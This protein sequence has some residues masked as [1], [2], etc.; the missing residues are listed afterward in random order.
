MPPDAFSIL[1]NESQLTTGYTLEF[2]ELADIL[3]W[4]DSIRLVTYPRGL[5]QHIRE[6]L[7]TNGPYDNDDDEPAFFRMTREAER[8]DSELFSV[9]RSGPRFGRGGQ[10]GGRFAGKCNSC[11]QFSHKARDC[12]KGSKRENEW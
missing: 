3:E 10:T 9:R 1:V 4:N 8:L 6:A 2:N 5:K 11:G 7:I 12:R